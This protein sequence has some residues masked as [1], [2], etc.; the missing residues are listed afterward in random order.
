MFQCTP[1]PV[2]T[3]AFV[4][5]PALRRRSVKSARTDTNRMVLRIET[6]RSLPGAVL[7][8]NAHGDHSA[9]Y[10]MIGKPSQAREIQ[11]LVIQRR[12]SIALLAVCACMLGAFVAD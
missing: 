4:M 6:R 11:M 2:N 9:T 12:A 8:L 10:C 3:A 5:S 7:K 1:A